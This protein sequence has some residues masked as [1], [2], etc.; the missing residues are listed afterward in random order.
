MHSCGYRGHLTYFFDAGS[1]ILKTVYGSPDVTTKYCYD[2]GQVIAEYDGS[3]NLLRKFIY[4]PGI[5]EPICIIDVADSNAVYYYHFDGLGSVAALS[6]VN[7]VIVE[8]YSY[9]VFGA[10]TIYDVNYTEISKSAI[11]NPYMFTARRADDETALYYYRARYY[12]FD[13]GRCLQTDPVGYDDGM[14]MYS[15][16]NNSPTNYIDPSGLCKDSLWDRWSELVQSSD[17]L[18]SIGEFVIGALER[19][20]EI[21][22]AARHP[23]KTLGEWTVN[24]L[25]DIYDFEVAAYDMLYDL[26]YNGSSSQ[27]YQTFY[28]IGSG[29]STLWSDI[30]NIVLQSDLLSADPATAGNAWGNLTVDVEVAVLADA[31]IHGLEIQVGE[32][33][34][35]APLGNRTP[36]VV[37]ELPHY[38]RRI[39]GADGNVIS[40]GSMKW[41]RPWQKGW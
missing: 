23:R 24:T 21:E 8:S 25:E 22:Q 27:W 31:L 19:V 1:R 28:D 11:G 34:R 4:G 39:I 17:V 40:G 10:P 38:H 30:M 35:I 29:Q 2:G 37:G 33:L 12:A 20:Y 13:I 15:Y 18:T 9:D 7:N 36:S 26:G 16:C 32:N 6:D 41:H 14:N 3:D 5:D